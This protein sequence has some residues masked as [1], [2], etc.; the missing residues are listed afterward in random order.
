MLMRFLTICAEEVKCPFCDTQPITL[1]P[2]VIL[3]F[4][5]GTG[6]GT[7]GTYFDA[8]SLNFPGVPYSAN[9]MNDANCHTQSGNI[10]NYGDKYQARIKKINYL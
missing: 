9:D 2:K 10:E 5:G 4:L 7:G 8:N 3:K 1:I 6:E